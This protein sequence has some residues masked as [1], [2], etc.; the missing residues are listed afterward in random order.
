MGVYDSNPAQLTN[1]PFPSFTDL[2]ALLKLDTSALAV[3]TWPQSHAEIAERALERGL[4]VFIEKPMG[5]T[6]SQSRRIQEAQKRSGRLV[7]VGYVERVNPAIVKLREVADLVEVIRSR[8]IRIGMRSVPHSGGVLLDLGCHS[9]DIAYHLFHAEP[10]VRSAILTTE[11]EGQSEYECVLELD[12]G[13]VRSHV[14]VRYA[15][16]RRRRLELDTNQE[17][18]EVSYTPAALKMGFSPPKLRKRPRSFEDLE[19]LSRNAETTFDIPKKEPMN[20]MLGLVAESVRGGAVVEPL[21][22]ADEALVTA[23]AIDDARKMATYR[24][25]ESHMVDVAP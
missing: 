16:I 12:Y 8:E 14:E 23:K 11:Q 9:M 24:F 13:H 22:N 18:Y 1:A 21:C 5:A 10:K 19:Q 17:Y 7:I 4:D 3:A 25:M 20:V 15:N 6:L 2:E